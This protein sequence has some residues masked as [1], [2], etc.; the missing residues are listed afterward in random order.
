M[1]AGARDAMQSRPTERL[2][3]SKECQNRS[4]F[5]VPMFCT[6]HEYILSSSPTMR[7]RKWNPEEG[8]AARGNLMVRGSIVTVFLVSL[9]E[10][11]IRIRKII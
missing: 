3:F 9:R 2:Q 5:D 7:C 8:K 6:I 10:R 1:Y 11:K 4:S